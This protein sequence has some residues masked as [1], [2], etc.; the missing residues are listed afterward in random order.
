[1]LCSLVLVC[2]QHKIGVP[3]S[4][5]G[6]SSLGYNGKIFFAGLYA[7]ADVAQSKIKSLETQQIQYTYGLFIGLRAITLKKEKSQIKAEAKRKK[8]AE[9]AA[10]Q[11]IKDDKKAAAEKVKADKKKATEAKKKKK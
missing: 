8:D 3:L 6:K 10:T 5:R 7:N 2:K 1:M 11:K 4:A 9:T